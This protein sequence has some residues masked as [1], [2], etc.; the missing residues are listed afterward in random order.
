M[1]ISVVDPVS[2][3]VDRTNYVLFQTFDIG[4][5]F[6]LAFCA[7]LAML[8]EG[9][10]SYLSCNTGGLG[11]LGGRPGGPD[12]DFLWQWKEENQTIIIVIVAAILVVGC[13]IGLLVCWLSCR[14]QFLFID[15]IVHNRAG[16]VAPWH[17]YRRE[18]N[19]LLLFRIMFNFV[20]V[21]AFVLLAGV[22]GMIAL[23]SIRAQEFGSAAALALVIGVPAFCLTV[24]TAGLIDMFLKD[25]LVP[26]MYLRRIRTIDAWVAF[27][28]HFLAGHLQSFVLYALFRVVIGLAGGTIAI[29]ATCLTCCLTFVPYL[30]T[31]I[32]L[33]L[34]VFSRSYG[35]CFLEQFGSEWTFFPDESPLKPSPHVSFVVRESP[36]SYI[37]PQA[38]SAPFTN[39]K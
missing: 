19:S 17:E 20:L 27:R 22:C 5:W 26:I 1:K 18:S 21:A 3:A 8:G 15:G 28:H 35:I 23:P 14:G 6:T 38:F 16:V 34:F 33:P 31:T 36:H 30:G 32:L 12:L 39:N 25:F 10:S 2:R 9:C 29:I 4:K 37:D 7:F 11:R 13:L 24:I